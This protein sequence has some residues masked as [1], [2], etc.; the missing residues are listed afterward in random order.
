[1]TTDEKIVLL[2]KAVLELANR[3]AEK[4]DSYDGETYI[5]TGIWLNDMYQI[6]SI[7]QGRE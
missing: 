2:A 4:N 6:E 5:S 3:S 1:M 7:A